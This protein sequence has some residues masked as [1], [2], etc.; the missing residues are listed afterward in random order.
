M[1]VALLAIAAAAGSVARYLVG[2]A[3]QS[4]LGT[5]FPWGTFTV[6]VSGSFLLGL[7]VGL[8]THHGL[9]ENV[10]TVLGVGMMGGY[11]TFSTWGVETMGLVEEAALVP[12]T[13]N[14]VG[15]VL[16]GM[17]AGG[18]GLALPLLW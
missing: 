14:A 17:L 13:L 6:N 9:P 7:I 3:I 16:A 4:R 8:V 12:A 2:K 1:I 11:T 18:A 15:S 5:A 10:K